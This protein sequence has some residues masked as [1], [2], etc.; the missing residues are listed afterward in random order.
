M[1][2]DWLGRGATRRVLQKFRLDQI[3]ANERA[4]L[5]EGI[6]RKVA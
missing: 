3:E 5:V 2:R 6:D 4:I 1:V